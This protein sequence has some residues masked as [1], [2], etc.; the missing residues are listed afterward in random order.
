VA[1]QFT[2]DWVEFS[3]IKLEQELDVQLFCEAV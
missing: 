2:H 3:K 1:W